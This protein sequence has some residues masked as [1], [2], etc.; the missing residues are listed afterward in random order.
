MRKSLLVVVVLLCV[1][2]LMAAQVSVVKCDIPYIWIYD[3]S[4]NVLVANG[5]P[6]GVKGKSD[7]YTVE[8]RIPKSFEG[9][10][11]KTGF[12]FDGEIVFAA[13]TVAK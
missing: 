9:G 2:S 4:G 6:T 12:S 10:W 8:F 7:R 11:P 3:R 1:A 5:V 13:D